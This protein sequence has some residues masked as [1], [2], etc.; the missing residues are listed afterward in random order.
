M[1]MKSA[2]ICC[3]DLSCFFLY[4]LKPRAL[5]EL[6]FLWLTEP[7][8]IYLF[9]VNN[10]NTGKECEICSKLTVKHQNEVIDVA[11]SLTSFSW[12]FSFSSLSFVN[13]EQLIVS[14]GYCFLHTQIGNLL[15]IH[16]NLKI[17]SKNNC[18]RFF[19][20]VS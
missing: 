6:F 16:I 11:L 17:S 10:K 18:S 14:W 9:K 8:N 19:I 4:K 20:A 3:H 5:P 7:A 15:F 1:T 12:F 13:F 2:R